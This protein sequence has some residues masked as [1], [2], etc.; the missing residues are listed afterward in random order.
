MKKDSFYLPRQYSKKIL[1]PA[2]TKG[3]SDEYSA[4][5]PHLHQFLKYR[6]KS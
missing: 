2:C 1:K 4:Y 3:L 5:T 6:K